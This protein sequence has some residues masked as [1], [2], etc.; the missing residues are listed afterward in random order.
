MVI[1]F[2]PVRI[3][4]FGISCWLFSFAVISFAFSKVVAD[5]SIIDEAIESA[6]TFALTCEYGLPQS[7]Q[8]ITVDVNASPDSVY[9][10]ES[11]GH[12]ER[13]KSKDGIVDRCSWKPTVIADDRPFKSYDVD[14]FAMHDDWCRLKI[15]GK[16]YVVTPQKGLTHMDDDYSKTNWVP[17]S[18]VVEAFDWPFANKGLFRRNAEQ[19]IARIVF[20]NNPNQVCL[21]ANRTK[22]GGTESVW[23]VNKK[24]YFLV[25]YN[26]E[27]D[28]LVRY[29]V[30]YFEKGIENPLKSIPDKSEGSP[31]SVV[32]TKWGKLD[33]EDVPISIDAIIRTGFKKD[34]PTL[35]VIAKIECFGVESKEFAAAKSKLLKWKQEISG[36]K[37]SAKP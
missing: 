20:Q 31:Y 16:E 10:Y 3:L 15:D 12:M 18:V 2:A 6:K 26:F 37:D 33:G 21:R 13:L 11:K 28:L 35:N 23:G 9:L 36:S 22:T 19:N 27:S 1:T 17:Q 5:D 24:L 30:V 7:L 4:Q 8:R 29:E 25:Y 34:N 32:S 14:V